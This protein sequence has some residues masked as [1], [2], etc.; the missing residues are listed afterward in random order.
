MVLITNL[1]YHTLVYFRH[2]IVCVWGGDPL[3]TPF[4]ILFCKSPSTKMKSLPLKITQ[5]IRKK[6]YTLFENNIGQI[7]PP[8]ALVETRGVTLLGQG[9]KEMVIPNTWQ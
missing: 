6:Q 3:T 4:P 1:Q 7:P 9:F 8:P 5:N 2:A